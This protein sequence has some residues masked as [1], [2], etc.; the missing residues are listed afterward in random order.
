MS[1]KLGKSKGGDRGERSILDE[2]PDL[3]WKVIDKYF[4]GDANILV[5]HQLSSYNLF[6]KDGL[7]KILRDENP[8]TLEFKDIENE[9]AFTKDADASIKYT[10]K[11]YLGDKDGQKVYYG[12]PIIYDIA[13]GGGGGEFEAAGESADFT[14]FM[15]PNEARLRNM[16]Y[17]TTVHVDV[18]VVIQQNDPESR[19]SFLLRRVYLGRFPIMVHSDLCILKG[20]T[21]QVRFYMGECRNDPGGYFII[22]GKEKVIVSQEKFADNLLNIRVLGGEDETSGDVYTHSADM[23]T[24]SEDPSKPVRTMSVRV[25]APTPTRTNRQIV[26]AIPNVRSP[27]PLF[28][29]MR[30]LGVESDREIMEHCLF[31]LDSNA[32]LLDLF[33]PSVHDA[34]KI[35]TQVQALEFIGLLTKW[36][37]VD[38]AHEVLMNYF[39]PQV[40]EMNYRHKAFMLGYIV[41]KLIRVVAKI[42]SPTDR[43]SFCNKRVEVSGT[44]MY[45]LFR[46]YYKSQFKNIRLAI[47]KEYYY[48][49]KHGKNYQ[50]ANF[51]RLVSADNYQ[52]YFK[53]RILET[54]VNRAFKGNW[55]ETAH[56]KRIGVIQDLNRLSHNSFIS[57]LRKINLEMSAG[58]KLVKPRLLHSSQWGLIDPVDVPDGANT[59]LHKHLA[60]A[61][62]ITSGCSAQPVLDW[63]QHEGGIL[64]VEECS[65]NQ[66]FHMSKIIVNGTLWGATNEPE[67]LIVKFKFHRR[68]ALI[69]LYISI[70]WLI[71]T[72]EIMIFTDAGRLCRP[73]FYHDSA[74]NRPSYESANFSKHAR[75]GDFSWMQLVSG[76]SKKRED[77]K[78]DHDAY[79]FYSVDELYETAA[80]PAAKRGDGGDGGEESEKEEGVGKEGAISTTK[81]GM[82][83]HSLLERLDREKAVIEF[84]DQSETESALISVKLP[85]SLSPV[86]A[87][88]SEGPGPGPAAAA[89]A[90]AATANYK[91]THYEIHPSLILGVMGNQ[92]S[93]PENNQF[94]R[95]AFGCGQAKQTASLYHSNFFS[96]M[97]KMSMVL[98]NGQ[99]PLVKSRYLEYINNEE[100]PNGENAI[101]AIMC[102]GGYNVEDSILFNEG[103]IKRGLF[104]ITYYNMYEDCEE[105]DAGGLAIARG[106]GGKSTHFSPVLTVPSVR[107]VSL[108]NDYTHLDAH[109]I[110]KEQTEL[111]DKTV[112]IG[113]ISKT[114]DAPDDLRDT[115]TVAKK[116]QLGFVDRTYMSESAQGTRLAKVRVREHR[117]PAVGDKF[118]SRCG[119]KGTVG[120]IIP[121]R[122]MPFAADGTRPDIIINPHAIPSRMTVGQLVETVMGKAC[123]LKGGFGDCTAFVNQGPRDKLFGDILLENHFHSSGNQI[124]HN[125]MSGEQ[126]E[127]SIF[128]GPT[129][130]MRLK[131]MVKDKINYRRTGPVT[132]LTRQP[133]QGR[134][135]DG[136]LRIGEMER[137]SIIAHGA[138]RFLQE[139]LMVRGDQY[140]L[141]ICNTTGMIAVYNESQNIFISP[142]ADGPIKYAGDLNELKSARVVN[143]TRHGRSFSVV[144]VP[145]ALKLLIQELQAMNVQ[146]RIITDFNIDQIESMGFSNNIG[147]LLM[148]D[149]ADLTT[150]VAETAGALGIKVKLASASSSK[151]SRLH[152]T[153]DDAAVAREFNVGMAAAPGNDTT[154]AAT[155][156]LKPRRHR[157][158]ADGDDS[159]DYSR[160]SV[161]EIERAISEY[162]WVYLHVNAVDGETYASMVT[163]ADGAPTEYWRLKEH[164]HQ[165]PNRFPMGWTDIEWYSSK[166]ISNS[167]KLAALK[168]FPTP[169]KNNLAR[170][171]AH[172]TSTQ[173]QKY[174]SVYP[175]SPKYTSIFDN[176]DASSGVGVGVLQYKD[177]SGLE[178]RILEIN[179]A[180]QQLEMEIED[181]KSKATEASPSLASSIRGGPVNVAIGPTK[182]IADKLR[183][184]NALQTEREELA[185]KLAL[186]LE[187]EH[188]A[189]KH[190]TTTPGA[191]SSYS[192]NSS[193]SANSNSSYAYG[194]AK[195][196]DYEPSSPIPVRP[197]ERM[198]LSMRGNAAS[199]PVA[200]NVVM[201][202]M[203]MMMMPGQP[204]PMMMMP[205]QQMP[206]MVAAA[207]Q[208]Q[209][210]PTDGTVSSVSSSS[211]DATGKKTIRFT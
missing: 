199:A 105:D 44:M 113:K 31:D 209:P 144:R 166:P 37:T 87:A 59:G 29:V 62:H 103:A 117:Y 95:D 85:G 18:R 170:A 135:N 176:G 175:T 34:N 173:E 19:K 11:L 69:P 8:I 112:L 167:D 168:L 74:T 26:V 195:S 61:A 12:K 17:G 40:G 76:F 169:V 171:Y 159:L 174:P 13:A 64:F 1:A 157:K 131:Q 92:I 75:D 124:L 202:P 33:V 119:Q 102:Y 187:I 126:I 70:R 82:P 196:P 191:D 151:K 21:S 172:V 189:I 206:A 41:N 109:G 5:K 54:G 98:N 79:N 123:V 137:D 57:H 186:N 20:L 155:T 153:G 100:H 198:L 164:N 116:G 152:A 141:A 28:I 140:Y 122:D 183:E 80:E 107:G 177:S 207:Q 50:G 14:H 53:E 52:Q 84:I 94:P 161:S 138:A 127:C 58:A 16:T 78:F 205:G 15:Y 63:L 179:K 181:V 55:G 35:F 60:M 104:N 47:D 71:Q 110:V 68:I 163:G 193:N 158:A 86:S 201:Q 36:K 208:P 2:M 111:T 32:Q 51:E 120:F 156:S 139:S 128:M 148:D 42:D 162:G 211:I 114:D 72:N 106:G 39:M 180:I 38:Y 27:V 204:M 185:S 73:V 203:P 66:L 22:N 142:M 99:V 188:R 194:Y 90:T 77:S 108:D 149:A 81:K 25:V 89:T 7:P 45:D 136:G 200:Q 83:S 150:V 115:S 210:N 56:T 143:V 130:Y 125:G 101:V 178:A 184:I 9:E 192:T 10:C 147:Q 3:P 132:A 88:A 97:D 154:T 121:E 48:Q 134:A 160:M 96:R 30:A 145:Y 46:E 93:F 197:G 49:K 24:I 146:M 91:Y 118:C 190:M 65:P 43:D 23:R 67:S 165:Y 182:I 129:Y 133:V 6:M 4:E